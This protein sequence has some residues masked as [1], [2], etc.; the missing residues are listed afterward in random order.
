MKFIH[1][2]ASYVFL[3]LL[4][5]GSMAD[6]QQPV[7]WRTNG[8]GVTPDANPP[9]VWSKQKNVIWSTKFSTRSNAQPVV[10]GDRIYVCAEPFTLICLNKADGKILWKRSNSYRDVTS[11][12]VLAE[13]E[14]ELAI[15]KKLKPRLDAVT[16]KI[17]QI[18]KASQKTKD[19]VEIDAF[20]DQ[21]IELTK[22]TRDLEEQLAKLP[23]ASKYTLP[24]TQRQYNGYTTATP[25]SDG[26]L[27]WGVFGNRVVACY[28]RDGKRQ[29]ASVLPDHPQAMWG[30]SSSPVLVGN[31]LI[32]N[33]EKTV[34]F[35]AKTGKQLWVTK[36]G[37]SWGSPVRAKIGGEDVVL[38]ANGRF[39][40]ISDG[41]ILVRVPPL[42]R[43]SP[44]VEGNTAFY[45]GVQAIAF[46]FP[47]KL[48]EKLVLQKRWSVEPKG[49]EFSSS[50]VVHD[51]LVYGVTT[52]GILNVL[53]AKSGEQVYVQRLNLGRGPVWPSLCLAGSYL[54]ISSRNGTTLVLKT[55]REYEEVA[56]NTLEYFIATPTFAGNRLYIRTSNRLYC[57]G[58]SS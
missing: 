19:Q 14:K 4:V 7:G 3:S 32:V 42:N 36:Y 21:I 53:D 24:I 2:L 48:T 56:R 29:W 55:G 1:R 58:E 26:R 49:G 11:D 52:N 20:D 44:V 15:A 5:T 50:P 30:H 16:S 27:V 37:Q 9:T 34:A 54:Y 8:S 39:L 41:K 46:D 40:R 47:K 45:I 33:I 12:E 28:D 6:A 22:Q 25:T 31:T 51:G 43:P 23:L 13:V 10:V 18:E 38:L 57:I 17:K 35:D